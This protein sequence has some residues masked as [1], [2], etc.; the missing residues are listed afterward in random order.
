MNGGWNL[1]KLAVSG[2]LACA[3]HTP[4]PSFAAEAPNLRVVY[5]ALGGSMAPVW[6]AQELGLFAKH[7]LQHNLNYLAATTAVQAMVAGSEVIAM[8]PS[9]APTRFTSPA[10]CHGSSFNYTAIRRSS[11]STISKARS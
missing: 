5:N 8:S 7:G 2:V 3:L 4:L 1:T 6:V 11:R 10:L 9:K